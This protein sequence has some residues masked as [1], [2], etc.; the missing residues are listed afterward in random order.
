LP[1]GEDELRLANFTEASTKKA[2]TEVG[3]FDFLDDRVRQ[4]FATTGPS[5]VIGSNFSEKRA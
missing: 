2:P 3:A 1:A 5:G 4:Y